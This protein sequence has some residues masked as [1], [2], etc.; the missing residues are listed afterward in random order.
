MGVQLGLQVFLQLF[1]LTLPNKGHLP[2]V[3]LAINTTGAGITIPATAQALQKLANAFL[4]QREREASL[5]MFFWGLR[6]K[7][8][9]M[10]V[11]GLFGC[12]D[13]E[14]QCQISSGQ[15]LRWS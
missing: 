4:K 15:T 1:A 8:L 2:Q 13:R 6:S 11:R 3:P 5:I 12:N 9:N 14:K 10:T 7:T